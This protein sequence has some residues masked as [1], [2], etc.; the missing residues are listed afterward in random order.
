MCV[1]ER[2]G[3]QGI[4]IYQIIEPVYGRV[5][6]AGLIQSTLNRQ[7]SF[8]PYETRIHLLWQPLPYGGGTQ[9]LFL[10]GNMRGYD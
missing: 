6:I 5:A 7:E 3:R 8:T 1:S 4:G 10:F 9:S 2:F